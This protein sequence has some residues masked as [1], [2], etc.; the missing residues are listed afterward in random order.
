MD[1]EEPIGLWTFL[2]AD[3]DLLAHKTGATRLGSHCF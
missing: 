2:A 3:R 1:P